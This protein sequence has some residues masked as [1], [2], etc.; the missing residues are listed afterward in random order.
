MDGLGTALYKAARAEARE[1]AALRERERDEAAFAEA[2][3][4]AAAARIREY[5]VT[6]GELPSTTVAREAFQAERKKAAEEQRAAEVAAEKHA[7][8]CSGLLASGRRP[9]TV[10][11]VLADAAGLL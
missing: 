6:H 11:Q 5:Y 9:R 10:A 7:D 4:L 8:Y 3:K 2:R 1:D